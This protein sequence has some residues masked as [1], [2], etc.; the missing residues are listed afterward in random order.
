MIS[1][2]FE[3]KNIGK[4]IRNKKK[5]EKNL[6]V[7]I[8][9]IQNQVFIEGDEID[10]YLAENVIY[11]ISVDFPINIAL[12]LL[13]E[14]YVLE[15]IPIKS[16]LNKGNLFRTKSRI[17]G[18]QGK[19]LKILE[20]LSN[21]YFKL[22]DNTVSIIGPSENIKD[23]VTALKSLIYGSKQSNV[24]SYLEKQRKK[25]FPANLGLKR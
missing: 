11:A 13:N 5:L 16:I 6:K 20:E 1:E 22:S 15:N 8:K 24:Y 10:V 17:I 12:L 18:K 23:A 2:N 9:R 4:I 14:D 19:T 21:C 7:K 3:K 25:Q